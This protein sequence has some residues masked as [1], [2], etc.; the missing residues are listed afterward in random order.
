VLEYID[1]LRYD[2]WSQI[3]KYFVD[4]CLLFPEMFEYIDILIYWLDTWSQIWKHFIDTCLHFF[5]RSQMFEYIRELVILK[6]SRFPVVFRI[7]FF[8]FFQIT[9]IYNYYQ[10]FTFTFSKVSSVIVERWPSSTHFPP[11][12][13]IY[14]YIYIISIIH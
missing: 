5:L 12:I 8:S 13:N 9:S 1:I 4:I 6:E 11:I 7:L 2:I 14:M 3:W 10:I